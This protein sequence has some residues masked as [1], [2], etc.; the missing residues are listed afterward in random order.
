MTTAGGGAVSAWTVKSLTG[1]EYMPVDIEAVT[2]NLTLEGNYTFDLNTDGSGDKLT[3]TGAVTM[4]SIVITIST[5]ANLMDRSKV[6][7]LV[8]G[9]NLSGTASL[10]PACVLPYGWKLKIEGNMLVVKYVSPG[11]LIKFY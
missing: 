5:P 9:S 6:Y 11:T 3:A 2:G 10:A 1:G 4:N 7:T 8:Q